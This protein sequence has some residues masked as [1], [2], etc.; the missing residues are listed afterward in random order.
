MSET[1]SSFELT[2]EQLDG[3]EFKVGFDKGWRKIP[4]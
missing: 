3:Y 2:L 4:A 1:V